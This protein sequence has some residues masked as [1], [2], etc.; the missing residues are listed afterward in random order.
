ML[1]RLRA[2]IQDAGAAPIEVQ[3]PKLAKG[4]GKSKQKK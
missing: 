2:L 1:G 4:K 3:D